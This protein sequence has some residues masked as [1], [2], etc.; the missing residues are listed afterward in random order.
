MYREASKIIGIGKSNADLV[1]ML[2]PNRDDESNQK[3][4]VVFV[5]GVGGL[6]KTTLA[7]A[8]YDK[9]KSLFGYGAFVPVGQDP[10]LKKVFRDI[11][12][13]LHKDKYTDLKYT[14]LDERQL[15]NELHDFLRTKRYF[16]IIDDI[17]E[18]Q[19][20]ERIKLALVENNHGSRTITTTR[21]FQ[22]ANEADEVYKLQTL[23]H[24]NSKRLFYMRLFGHEDKCPNNHQD[25]LSSAI[26]KKCGG[27]P[28]AI[29]TMASL[30]LGKSRENWIE[31]CNSP[32][33]YQDKDE[34]HMENTTHILSLSYYDL[35]SHL[36]T[37]LLYLS[38]FPED[39]LIDRDSLI[40]KWIA[41]GFV[42]KKPGRGLF[43]VGEQYFH[44]LINRSMIQGVYSKVYG[45]KYCRVHDMVLDLIVSM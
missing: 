13:D 1:S 36:K 32:G 12:I 15:I 6:D 24:D 9:L 16:I 10:V 2:S 40:W 35:P 41:E 37:C 17:W 26:L 27:I 45:I 14:M 43:E 21:K 31:V 39:S 33:F 34:R 30:L 28:L 29:I 23:S 11:L 25:E 20:W 4:K 19:T 7:K 5:V 3:M 42:E 22:V 8:V 18:P 38:V 44:D